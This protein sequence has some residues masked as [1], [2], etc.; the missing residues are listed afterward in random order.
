MH[1]LTQSIMKSVFTRIVSSVVVLATSAHLFASTKLPIDLGPKSGTNTVNI[2]V[3]LKL[4]NRDQLAKFI[5]STSDRKSPNYHRFL[6]FAQFKATYAPLPADVTAVVNDLKANKIAVTGV[7]A[8]NLVVKATG[9]VSD[10][11]KYFATSVHNYL[12]GTERYSSPVK[13]A[14]IP[15][16]IQSKVS[17]VAGLSSKHMFYPNHKFRPSEI[18]TNKV[19]APKFKPN[20]TAT[21]VPG[22]FSVGD[23]V[24][25]YQV[26]PLYDAGKLG[27]GRTIGIATL[28]TFDPA[29]AYGYWDGIGLSYKPNRITVVDVDGGGDYSGDIETT[30][31]VEQSGGLAPQ[32]D[33]VVYD[34]PN[35]D[36]GF[37]DV[38][39]QAV[40]DNVVD[41][42]SVSW[43][44]PEIFYS[45]DYIAAFD[46]VLMEA[47]AQGISLFSASGDA[48]AFDINQALTVPY[49]TKV[50]S[51]DYPGSSPW[52][53]SAGGLTIAGDIDFGITTIT[54]PYDRPWG[55]NYLQS[56]LDKVIPY[57]GYLGY[58]PSGAGGGVSVVESVPDYQVNL[59]GIQLS[60]PSQFLRLGVTDNSGG[61]EFVDP[62]LIFGYNQ[63]PDNFAGRNLPDISLNADPNTGYLIYYYGF[64]FG[65]AGGTSFVAPQLNGITALLSQS[66]GSRLG[67]LNPALYRIAGK[68]GYPIN[69]PFNDITYG[70]NLGF[71]AVPGYDPASGIGSINAA[72]LAAALAADAAP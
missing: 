20:S 68:V 59:P 7:S 69:G 65:Y 11:N 43:G 31:A 2:S 10:I 25:L 66:A 8:N 49:F 23:V 27:Q 30:L 14:K 13:P 64:W 50:V 1:C 40:M 62:L 6:S 35:T 54:I 5:R 56:F 15:A 16:R 21:G 41:T 32:A 34:A 48:G 55:W 19:S 52:V 26:Q 36:Y 61:F 70:D 45:P 22:L 53:T 60:Q 24:D 42:L 17:G 9:K 67:L 4:R 71:Q 46:Q 12:D 51:A 39:N 33:I 63:I 38:F 3:G 28:A 58:F 37:L 47:A 29:D 72:N 18:G 57:G 44:G